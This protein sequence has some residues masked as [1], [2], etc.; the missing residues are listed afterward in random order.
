MKIQ[1]CGSDAV[2]I[3][4]HDDVQP[5]QVVEVADE[6]GAS[7]LAAGSSFAADGTVSPP[8]N[9]LW[10]VPAKPKPTKED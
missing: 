5:G 9:P 8:A 3:P 7:L 4:G 2:D 6:V 10:S 1:Y